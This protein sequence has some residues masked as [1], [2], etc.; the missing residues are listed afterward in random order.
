M[1]SAFCP[2]QLCITSLEVSLRDPWRFQR[3]DSEGEGDA[4][5]ELLRKHFAGLRNAQPAPKVPH[6][7][8]LV[9][10]CAACHPL[11]EGYVMIKAGLQRERE[12][13]SRDAVE[14]R[15]SLAVFLPIAGDVD[16]FLA[17]GTDRLVDVDHGL[18]LAVVLPTSL[19]REIL[20]ILEMV[21]PK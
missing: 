10:I 20:D 2:H 14:L 13:L 18:A 1:Q 7:C 15:E 16:Q 5:Y 4:K 19:Y 9:V 21:M 3:T 8:L 11:V 12:H 17:V 6:P